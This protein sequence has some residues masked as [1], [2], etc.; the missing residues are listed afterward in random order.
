MDNK[1]KIIALNRYILTLESYKTNLNNENLE[2][3][4]TLKSKISSLLDENHRLRFN[5]I[6]F[7]SEMPDYSD[8]RIEDLPF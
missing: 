1:N 5:R 6:E 2:K 4:E 7:Y 3:F 8:I